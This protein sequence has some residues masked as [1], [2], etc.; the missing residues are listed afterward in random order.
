MQPCKQSVMPLSSAAFAIIAFL[1]FCPAIV[2]YFALH[3]DGI[4][5]VIPA[6][7]RDTGTFGVIKNRAFPRGRIIQCA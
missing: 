2:A 7:K 3:K 6:V 5:R 1:V 4:H